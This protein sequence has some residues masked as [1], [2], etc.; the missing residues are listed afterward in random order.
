MLP[1]VLCVS[2]N[3]IMKR[4]NRETRALLLLLLIHTHIKKDKEKEKR[5]HFNHQEP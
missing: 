2:N 1:T 5:V 4:N 3:I